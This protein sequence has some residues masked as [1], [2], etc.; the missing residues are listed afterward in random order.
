M[1]IQDFNFR[2]ELPSGESVLLLPQNQIYQ[3]YN[4]QDIENT[5]GIDISG[6]KLVLIRCVH[7]ENKIHQDDY[8]QNIEYRIKVD[9]TSHDFCT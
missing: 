7:F 5:I 8:I 4:I 6:S 3:I 2:R 9:I 1:V